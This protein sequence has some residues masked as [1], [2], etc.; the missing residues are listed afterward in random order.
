MATIS[1]TSLKIDSETKARIQRLADSRRRSPHWIMREA[2]E[3]YVAREEKREQ[4]RQDALA[5]WNSYQSTGLHAT[6]D[7]ANAWLEKLEKGK[8]V[9]TPK[10][11]V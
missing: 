9:A 5:A 2:V 3:Q 10:C 4:L 6:A 7:E 8:D 11:H 1:T